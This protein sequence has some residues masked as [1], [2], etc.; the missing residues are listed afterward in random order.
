M[1]AYIHTYIHTYI[2]EHLAWLSNYERQYDSWNSLQ[3]QIRDL[4]RTE[5]Q[6]YSKFENNDR[7]NI[8]FNLL[9]CAEL[10]LRWLIAASR[11]D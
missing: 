5:R 8:N 10:Q 11:F 4:R 9:L 6:T 7:K 2:N 1:H 3:F